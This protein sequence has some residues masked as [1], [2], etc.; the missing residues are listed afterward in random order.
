MSN[1][2]YDCRNDLSNSAY[3]NVS[4]CSTLETLT[5]CLSVRSMSCLHRAERKMAPSNIFFP[6]M[7][8]GF[9]LT[10]ATVAEIRMEQTWITL[11]PPVSKLMRSMH[12]HCHS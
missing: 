3:L 1:F 2:R 8:Q 9:G 6:G 10:S 7:V 11:F 4:C 12:V 5:K